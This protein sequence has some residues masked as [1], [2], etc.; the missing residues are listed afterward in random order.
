MR[1]A[2]NRLKTSKKEN[3]TEKKLSNQ[4]K[5]AYTCTLRETHKYT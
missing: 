2:T 4:E 5:R 3:T 1:K